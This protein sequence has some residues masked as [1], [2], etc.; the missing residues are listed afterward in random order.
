MRHLPVLSQSGRVSCRS[1]GPTSEGVTV[2]NTV[3][4]V[5]VSEQVEANHR[6][7]VGDGPSA[8][9]PELKEAKHQDGDQSRPDWM[10]SAFSECRRRS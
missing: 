2:I 9:G 10:C 3:V 6:H 8:G 5:A 7:Q 1:V 4:E